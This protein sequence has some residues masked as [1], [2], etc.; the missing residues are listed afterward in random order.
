LLS[1]PIVEEDLR[2]TGRK[3]DILGSATR[4]AL[5]DGLHDS[6]LDAGDLSAGGEI[7]N[8]TEWQPLP[9]STCLI[10]SHCPPCILDGF[11]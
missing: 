8:K 2:H 6:W 5:L 7:S 10:L 3:V 9:D 4:Q 1:V 11:G